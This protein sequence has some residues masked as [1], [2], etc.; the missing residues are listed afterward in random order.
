ML[1]EQE[2]EQT[3]S[4]S[5]HIRLPI[6]Y[7]VNGVRYRNVVIDELLGLDDHLVIGK[8]AG[9]NMAKAS[10][11]VLCRTIQ[12]IEGIVPAKKNSES[13]LDRSIV[14]N[15]YGPDRDFILSRVYML[16]GRTETIMAGECPRCSRIWQEEL[17]LGSLPVVEW[18]DNKSSSLDFE[19][20]IGV[21]DPKTGEKQKTGKIDFITGKIQELTGEVSDA[22]EMIDSM[23]VALI[24]DFGTFGK[25][26]KEQ[27]KRM[28]QRDRIILVDM[29]ANDF[30]GIK[31]TK[32]IK[33]DCGR[34][35]EARADLSSFSD[36]QR[37]RTKH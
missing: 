26:T 21:A 20:E 1:E 13:M 5:D 34:S 7:E 23:L 8:K 31:M 19:L 16:S 33:C 36:G 9:K 28:K 6:G 14:Q 15:M 27:A 3:E 17:A 25:L 29:I 24:R 11:L 35:Y 37:R 18:E 30:P 4:I 10:S 2:Q 22:A 32:D 12:E